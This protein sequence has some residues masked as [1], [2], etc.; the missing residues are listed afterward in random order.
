MPSNTKSVRNRKVFSAPKLV[1]EANDK[2][3]DVV[4]NVLSS[5]YVNARTRTSTRTILGKAAQQFFIFEVIPAK[6]V[7]SEYQFQRRIK[8][9][10]V[11]V[12]AGAGKP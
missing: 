12:P 2:R 1:K 7:L 11:S 4:L 8:C 5:K 3:S 10:F 9:V 6:H